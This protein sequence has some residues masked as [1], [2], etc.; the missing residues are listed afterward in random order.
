MDRPPQPAEGHHPPRDA[1]PEERARLSRIST[2]W[3]ILLHARQSPGP[4]MVQAQAETVQRYCSAVYRYLLAIVRD[5][6]V[7][8]DLAQDFAVRFLEGGFS[9]FEPGR[10]RFRDYVKAILRNLVIDHHRAR[11]AGV[12]TSDPPQESSSALDDAELDGR[13][14]EAWRAE[15]FAQAWDGLGR[16]ERESGSPW[17]SVLSMRVAHPE[18]RSGQMAER[19]GQQ[20]GKPFTAAAVRQLLHRAREKFAEILVEE[21]RRSVQNPDDLVEELAELGLLDYCR[22]VLNRE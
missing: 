19:L 13:F 11:R 8:E 14:L 2:R 9:R 18:L 3:S 10:G 6:D 20:L 1:A 4:T 16:L 17:H 7:A 12:L 15:L 22:P 21:V 5:P